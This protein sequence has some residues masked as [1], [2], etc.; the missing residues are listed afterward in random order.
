MLKLS[1]AIGFSV[2]LLVASAPVVSA[3]GQQ[4]APQK[5]SQQQQA[6]PNTQLLVDNVSKMVGTLRENIVSLNK[7]IESSDNALKNAP[8]ILD[9]LLK[10]VE[11][12]NGSIA[13][14]SET[15]KELSRMIGQ[16]EGERARV[17]KRANETGNA[18]LQEIAGLWQEKVGKAG[19]LRDDIS[20]ERARSQALIN[21]LKENREIV[22]ELV[23]L[24]AADLVIQN[25]QAIRD[26]LV[27]VN[28]D[29]Q[30]MLDKAKDLDSG[31]VQN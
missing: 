20:R 2:A 29:M 30:V 28:D 23:K 1:Q 31:G 17:A 6:E 13:E 5:P 16:Y 3:F 9:D 25:M 24:D 12:I 19:S 15:W 27:S 7:G 11:E 8:Q 21:E 18:K 4:S 14:D 26:N 10:S 22:V